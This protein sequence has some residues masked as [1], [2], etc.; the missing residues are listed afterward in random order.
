MHDPLAVAAALDPTLIDTTAV[1]VDVE[2]AGTIANGM[3]LADWRDVWR[4]RPNAEVAV[5]VGADRVIAAFLDAIE[6]LARQP[7]TGD[8]PRAV[9]GA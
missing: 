3:T 9:P 2:T 1:A 5:G 4:R 6:R 8:Q 7:S